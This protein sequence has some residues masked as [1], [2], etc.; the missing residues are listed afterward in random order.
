MTKY[1]ILSKQY[2]HVPM[3]ESTEWVAWLNVEGYLLRLDFEIS[4]QV[5]IADEDVEKLMRL[6]IENDLADENWWD[7]GHMSRLFTEEDYQATVAEWKAAG[8]SE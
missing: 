2:R 7:E 4:D 6:Q 1:T 3:K 8:F 5:T